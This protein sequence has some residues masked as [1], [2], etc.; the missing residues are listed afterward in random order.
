[1][2]FTLVDYQREAQRTKSVGFHI[3]R[4]EESVGQ[5]IY[6]DMLHAA[7]GMVTEAGELLEAFN[8]DGPLD[9]V[10]LDEE[11]GDFLWYL[12]IYAE[13]RHTTFDRLTEA[14][15]P[16]LFERPRENF[17]I[18][19]QL[20]ILSARVLDTFKK[21]LFY[22]KPVNFSTADAIVAACLMMIE[23]YAKSRATTVTAL[24]ERNL[25]KLRTRFPE[26]FDD[27]RALFRNLDAERET[28]ESLDG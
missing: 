13:A 24:A 16:P 1:M 9:L 22:G 23:S 3:N 2:N 26:K 5:F 11:A 14:Y 18:A 21:S 20:M 8:G 10:N 4:M 27:Q 28:L 12:A 17:T 7:I 6:R 25:R 15:D 19:L